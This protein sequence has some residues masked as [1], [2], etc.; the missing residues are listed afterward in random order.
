[1]G[2]FVYWWGIVHP[3]MHISILILSPAI[4]HMLRGEFLMDRHCD[5]SV[6]AIQELKLKGF[7]VKS[8]YI[9]VN[10]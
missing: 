3:L 2:L 1:M 7:L 4:L 10:L 5:L 6:F 8:G 9:I